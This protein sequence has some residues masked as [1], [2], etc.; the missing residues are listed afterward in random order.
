MKI[1]SFAVVIPMF[2][3]EDGADACVR[4]VCFEMTKLPNKTALIA[5]NDGSKDR[6]GAILTGLEKEVQPLTV[7]HHACNRGYGAALR[8]GVETARSLDFEYVLFMDS[9]LTNHPGDIPR[10]AA[11][12]AGGYDV[13]KATRYS[14]GGRVAGVPFHR[15]AISA[16]GNRLA[17]VLFRLPL[18]DSTNGFRAVR[19]SLLLDMNLRE[20]RFPIIMEELYWL[21]Y[22]TRSFAELPVELTHRSADQRRTAFV[23]TPG[24]F[25][26]Y[27]KYPVRAFFGLRPKAA[28][29]S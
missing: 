5:V 2:D 23:Y 17:K 10:F 15:V 3:E 16:A 7:V 20:N 1:P 9:D 11:K 19:V 24:V 29:T 12:M 27:L 25:W 21:K 18:H 14:D 22:R 8:T 13:I 4:A 6:T 28:A 26:R